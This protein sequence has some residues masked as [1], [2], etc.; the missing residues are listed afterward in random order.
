[1]N[2]TWLTNA[3][4]GAENATNGSIGLEPANFTRSN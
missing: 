1:M 4:F 3:D 2:S